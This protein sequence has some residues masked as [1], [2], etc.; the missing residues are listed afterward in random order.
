VNNLIVS[1]NNNEF[2]TRSLG[3]DRTECAE[4]PAGRNRG[5]WGAISGVLLGASFWGAILLFVGV[6]KL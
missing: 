3:D 2:A 6:I 5:A 4:G 1:S